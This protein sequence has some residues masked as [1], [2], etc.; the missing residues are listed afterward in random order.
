MLT[1]ITHIPSPKLNHG[2]LTFLTRQ[3]I[4]FEKTRLQHVA[5]CDMLRKCSVEVVTLNENI[6]LPDSA[7]V[8]DTAFVLDEIGL[9]MPMGVVSRSAE[10]S[11]IERE[12]SKFRKIKQIELPAKL[13]GGDILRVGKNIFVGITSRTNSLGIHNLKSIV[14]P[15]GY[16]VIGVKVH[17]CLHLKT[18]CTVLNKNTILINPIWIDTRPFETF[19]LITVPEEEP[20]AANILQIGKIICMHSGFPKTGKLIEKLGL[21]T[22]F[23]DISEF[24]KAEAGLTCLS[25]IFNV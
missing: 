20:F 3:P 24:Q 9:M 17:G 8:E 19:N 25:I 4:D 16:K 13:E 10:T 21:K 2:E 22:E 23:T 12:L 15:Y 14:K 18:G 11:V 6:S 1:A 5:Y 7:F